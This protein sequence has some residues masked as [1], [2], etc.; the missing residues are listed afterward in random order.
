M[1]VP[2]L[3]ITARAAHV[4]EDAPLQ[5]RASVPLQRSAAEQGVIMYMP[6]GVHRVTAG[7]AGTAT[8]EIW[9]EVG[10]ESAAVV[11]ASFGHVN[12]SLAPHRVFFDREHEE[13]DATGW[14][15]EFFWG[16]TPEPG[17]YARCEFSKLGRE[18]I[19]G[20]IQRGFS[21]AFYT[22]AD[23]PKRAAVRAGQHYTVPA[24]KRGSQA[25]PARIIGIYSPCAGGFTNHP[26]FRDILPLWAK[27]AGPS[28]TAKQQ[29]HT[30]RMK[31][32]KAQLE[33]DIQQVHT[34]LADLKG[35][36]VTPEV[37]AGIQ[38]K[39]EE[40]ETLT[41]HLEAAQAEERAANAERELATIRAADAQAAVA[42]AIERGVFGPKDEESKAQWSHLCTSDP[43]NIALLDKMP[44]RI[45]LGR[46]ATSS[47][48]KARQGEALVG[49]VQFVRAD[50]R[51]VFKQAA[52][53]T[54]RQAY[55]S[56]VPYKE[57]P[58][59]AKELAALYAREIKPRLAEG[60]DIPM[61][62]LA[63]VLGANTLGTLAQTLV[64]IRSLE[65]LTQELPLIKAITMDMSDEIVTYGSTIYTRV[66]GIPTA[67]AYNTSTGFPTPNNIT[68]TDVGLTF[69][70]WYGVYIQ[71]LGHEIAGT[72]RSLFEEQ[73]LGQAYAL[74]DQ[75]VDGVLALITSANFTNTPESAGSG[76]FARQNVINMGTALRKRGVPTGPGMRTLL[77]NSD[78]F[79]QLSKDNAL[80]T[81][82]AN[83]APDR[84]I[85]TEGILPNVHGFRVL[86]TPTLPATALSAGSL[87]GFGFSKSALVIG[88]R[89]SNDY[90]KTL[91]GAAH[92]N[93]QVITTPAGFSANLVQW[94]DHAG[95]AANSRLDAIWAHSKGQ[96]NAGQILA[97]P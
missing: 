54:A 82:A 50:H 9:V 24:G 53:I 65:L 59:I 14:P 2:P 56:G 17:I 41:A 29:P 26:A 93:L 25:N 19:D 4:R 35:R 92:G 62:D 81:L 73:A 51:D 96:D 97:Q 30:D 39:N 21:P 95:V 60:D 37:E 44:G 27:Q 86:D 10:P 32:S 36:A 8:T 80:V 75:M 90:T 55:N 64:A 22:D 7:L 68:T 72:V 28:S 31:K 49:R 67:V 61:S 66:L 6:A 12:Q 45:T 34:D 79:G 18:L 70:Q 71:F 38:Q 85:I 23:V 15:M 48:V 94:V 57:R 76:T 47:V 78:Y 16:E 11:Q 1:I 74:A 46:P 52:A 20:R 3:P 42:R 40:L 83:S 84:T 91:P 63:P 77:L 88:T 43:K 89:L 58:A 33:A 87:A 13:K 69:N 5:A